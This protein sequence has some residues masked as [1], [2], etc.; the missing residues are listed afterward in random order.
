MCRAIDNPIIKIRS[1]DGL[2]MKENVRN[3]TN[4]RPQRIAS[5]NPIPKSKHILFKN[6]KFTNFDGVSRQRYEML[7]DGRLLEEIH[8]RFVLLLGVKK[9][10][11]P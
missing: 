3:H 10:V 4:S 6:T 9:N 11:D 2:D 8:I 5:A 1:Y 7:S